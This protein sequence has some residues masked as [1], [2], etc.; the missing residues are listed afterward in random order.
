M[1]KKSPFIPLTNIDF[2]GIAPT[3]AAVA[4]ANNV[5]TQVYPRAAEPIGSPGGAQ[6]G[7]GAVVTPLPT[8]ARPL[9]QPVTEA[10]YMLKVALPPE[11]HVWVKQAADAGRCSKQYVLLQALQLAGAPV[12]LDK[13]S[14]DGRRDR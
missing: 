11:V 7:Q 6:A 9:P 3:V 13:V 2:S 5:P 10:R 8:A 14:K 12:D 4:T 1:T